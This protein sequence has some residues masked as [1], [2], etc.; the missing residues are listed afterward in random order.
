MSHSQNSLK[1]FIEGTVGVT[2]GDSRSLDNGSHNYS[3]V[4]CLVLFVVDSFSKLSYQN[5]EYCCDRGSS[6]SWA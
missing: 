3:L 2:K 6:R 5:S 4:S 1:G